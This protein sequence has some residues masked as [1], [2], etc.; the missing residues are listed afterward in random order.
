MIVFGGWTGSKLLCCTWEYDLERD[1]S[2]PRCSCCHVTSDQVEEGCC[3]GNHPERSIWALA[4]LHALKAGD[5]P[6]RWTGRQQSSLPRQPLRAEREG[7]TMVCPP[8]S[9]SASSDLEVEHLSTCRKSCKGRSNSLRTRLSQHEQDA[10]EQSHHLRRC[11]DLTISPLLA[12][13]RNSHGA[14][15]EFKTIGW[16]WRVLGVSYP[17]SEWSSVS[18][19]ATSPALN[20]RRRLVSSFSWTWTITRTSSLPLRSI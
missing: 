3:A 13:T 2:G 15:Q 11:V 9:L 20:P 7:S 16:T 12:C 17:L 10:V 19:V 4:H 18:D 5:P 6:P 8:F 1:R 14:V